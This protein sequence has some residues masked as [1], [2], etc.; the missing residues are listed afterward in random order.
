[1]NISQGCQ[2]MLSVIGDGSFLP[3]RA[4]LFM[5]TLMDNS[6]VAQNTC[7]QMCVVGR[8]T[9]VGAGSTFTD[10]NLLSAPIRARDGNG[11]LNFSNRPFLEAVWANCRL[12]SG[13]IFSCRATESDVVSP[14]RNEPSSTGCTPEDATTSLFLCQSPPTLSRTTG[15]MKP[16]EA[17]AKNYDLS[18]SLDLFDRQF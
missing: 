11:E 5:T 4:S 3:F 13:M 8:N 2:L 18:V 15:L 1:M 10:F 17:G 9:F 14:L 12:G 16:A 6:M 7:L